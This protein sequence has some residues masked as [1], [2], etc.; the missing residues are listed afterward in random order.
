MVE[1]TH[2]FNIIFRIIDKASASL[3]SIDSSLKRV[4]NQFNNTGKHIGGF[5]KQM[6]GMGLGMTFFLFGVQMQLQRV[7][8]NMFNVFTLAE[9]ETGA[10]N[11]Q[12]NIVRANLAAISIAFFDA[13]AQSGLFD[14]V[15]SFVQ[16]AADWFLNLSDAT[17]QWI[18]S[19]A[20]KSL[21]L[22]IGIQMAGQT[23]LAINTLGSFF[24]TH[25]MPQW[26]KSLAGAGLVLTVGLAVKS[27]TDFVQGD[28]FD[29]ITNGISA[30][31]SGVG[32]YG[33]VS[34]KAGVAGTA[35]TLLVGLQLVKEGV[36]FRTLFAIS[37]AV[38]GV[39]AGIG[40]WFL[41]ELDRIGKRIFD[42]IVY[43][44]IKFLNPSLP[45]EKYNAPSMA[46]SM[47][48]AIG[49]GIMTGAQ[50]GYEQGKDW[51]VI[52]SDMIRSLDANTEA[53]NKNTY[54]PP[55]PIDPADQYMN[56]RNPSVL[57]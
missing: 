12:F 30:I 32:T 34:G 48:P 16:K 50:R 18:A 55:H 53:T 5:N 44:I 52:F 24:D 7:L 22:V 51:D 20:I 41:D 56:Y 19:F 25:A 6:L 23:L 31:L 9:G 33:I 39:F 4:A 21:A 45:I 37:G 28:I 26:R 27:I 14:F 11:Q 35:F 54:K 40:N 49:A 15:L 42:V 17:R 10:L 38:F 36:F 1:S 2:L 8:R 13:F 47:L 3:T 46:A 29:G 43:P 57:G